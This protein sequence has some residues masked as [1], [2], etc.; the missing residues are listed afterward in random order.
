MGRLVTS[1]GRLGR[2]FCG[3]REEESDGPMNTAPESTAGPK[4]QLEAIPAKT[5]VA[6]T[7][8]ASDAGMIGQKRDALATK[9]KGEAKGGGTGKKRRKGK[10]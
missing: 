5:N 3:L 10:K 2:E 7:V 6:P 8:E 9:T 4:D 1:L